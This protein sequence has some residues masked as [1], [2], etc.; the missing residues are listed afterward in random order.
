MY[1]STFLSVHSFGHTFCNGNVLQQENDSG[2]GE[3]WSESFDQPRIDCNGTNILETPGDRLKN[4]DRISVAGFAVAAVQPCCNCQY[5]DDKRI[6]SHHDEE[7][8]PT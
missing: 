7:E 2:D 8:C 5:Q 6:P 3:L 1:V 4:L